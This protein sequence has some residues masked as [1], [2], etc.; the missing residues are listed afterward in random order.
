MKRFSM[1]AL[2]ALLLASCATGEKPTASGLLKSNFQTEVDGKKTDLF[3]LRNANNMEVCIT[4]FGGRIV[5]VMVPDR[6]GVMRD[7]VLGFDS[8]RDYITIPSDFG[9]SI[10]RYANRINQGRFTLDGVEY[11]LPRNNYGHCLHGGPN[12]FQYQVYDA[13]Q[14]GPQELE[15]TYLSKDGEEGFPGNITC[16]VLMTLTDDNAIDIRYEA[17]TDQPTIVNMT[18]HSYF[19]LDGDAGS[20]SDH[21]LTIDADYYTPVDST[22]MTTGEIAPVEGTPMDF[23]TATPVGARIDDFDFVQLKNGNG[24]DHNWVLN[25]QRDIT[26]KC[27]TLESPKTGIVLDVYTNE[28]GIQVYAGNF[29]DGTIMGKKGIVYNQRASVCLETQK[30]PDTPNKPDWPSAV[31][32]PGEKYNSHCVFKFSIN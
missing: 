31:L 7:V 12:G 3:V 18:N 5:S 26:H 11:V 15:L 14:T 10:G 8:I 19:N 28:P 9:A 21:L 2:S 30:Y 16:K 17:E 24:Y 1:W 25:T 32:R 6:E 13:R 23:R 29:L 4:N 22:F 27:V 20:N